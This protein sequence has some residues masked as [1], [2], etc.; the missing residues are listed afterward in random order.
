[1][2]ISKI[3]NIFEMRQSRKLKIAHYLV[4]KIE[5]AKGKFKMS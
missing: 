4:F 5:K 1:M 2:E 3:V